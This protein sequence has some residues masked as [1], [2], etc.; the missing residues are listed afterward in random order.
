MRGASPLDRAPVVRLRR[1][2]TRMAPI[3]SAGRPHAG[4]ESCA[5]QQI[6]DKAGCVDC[7]SCR[8]LASPH[9]RMREACLGSAGHPQRRRETDGSPA[10]VFTCVELL[11]AFL[12]SEVSGGDRRPTPTATGAAPPSRTAR[13]YRCPSAS[14][15]AGRTPTK[16]ALRR[17][18]NSARGKT[19]AVFVAIEITYRRSSACTPD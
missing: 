18:D 14:R 19:G 10:A 17:F 8:R 4:R 6:G 11:I 7:A 16:L 12:H 5:C 13:P 1:I 3:P 15:P 9:G 2:T